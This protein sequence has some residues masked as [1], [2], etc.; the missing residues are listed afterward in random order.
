MVQANPGHD[1]LLRTRTTVVG[2]GII[3]VA[4]PFWL[5]KPD[6][7]GLACQPPKSVMQ[8]VHLAIGLQ[9]QIEAAD[10]PTA[11]PPKKPTLLPG[12]WHLRAA[13]VAGGKCYPC[14]A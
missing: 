8:S 9:D 2:A 7:I 13:V 11:T 12:H 3:V 5:M 14:R 6:P 4:V 10:K 1:P